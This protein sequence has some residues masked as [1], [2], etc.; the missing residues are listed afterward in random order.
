MVND[1]YQVLGLR[2]GASL[3]EVKK[4]YRAMAKKFHPDQFTEASAK[5]LAEEKMQRINEAYDAITTGQV[6]D[7][8]A[9]G[10]GTAGSANANPWAGRHGSF[11]D[12]RTYTG[13]GGYG[14]NP[15]CFCGSGN[16][17]DDLCCLLSADSCCECLGGDLVPCC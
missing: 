6:E 9:A 16:C 8:S 3:E 10:Q 13:H 1:P 11:Y 7:P 14:M 2:R 17:C 12:Q 5:E 15:G 4:A